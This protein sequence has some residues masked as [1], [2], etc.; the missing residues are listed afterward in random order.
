MMMH[1]LFEFQEEEQKKKRISGYSAFYL[2]LIE[3]LLQFMKC[4][5]PARK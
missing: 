3:L 2:R 1:N 5:L 4:L